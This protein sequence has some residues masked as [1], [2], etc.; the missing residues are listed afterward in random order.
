M[1]KY[2]LILVLLSITGVG[3]GQTK[4]KPKQKEVVPTQKEMADMMKQ[5]EEAMGQMSPEDKKMMDS[6]GIK[7][8]SFNSIPAVTDAQLQ[9]AYENENKIVP[10]KDVGRIASIS[11]IPLT[12]TTMA[13]FLLT[14]H[15]KVTMQLK[16]ASKTK[17]EEIYKL[18][19]VQYNSDVATL[20][21]M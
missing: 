2:A 21:K 18:I 4:P 7:M 17:G 8:P 13:A 10:L 15:S 1:K 5:M 12:T 20:T 16:I 9:E 19:K 3:I 11:K 6:M 14:T